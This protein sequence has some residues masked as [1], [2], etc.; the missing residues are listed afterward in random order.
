MSK[1]L[2]YP[3][4]PRDSADH[5]I[6]AL[7]DQELAAMANDAGCTVEALRSSLAADPVTRR[8]LAEAAR[9]AER[10]DGD[11]ETVTRLKL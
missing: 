7:S 2:T 5:E 1:P 8:E 4:P 11:E 10:I 6:V 9:I 3:F